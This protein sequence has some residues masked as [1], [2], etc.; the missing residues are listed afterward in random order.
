MNDLE[1]AGR[2]WTNGRHPT[3][4]AAFTS[5][6]ICACVCV[7]E[8]ALTLFD[9]VR[10]SVDEDVER[11]HHAGDGDD[12]EGDRTHDLPPLARRH[13]QLLPLRGHKG[14]GRLV[15]SENF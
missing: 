7:R 12:V 8:S 9:F 15:R 6:C 5:K 13:L 1:T 14:R 4:T 3:Q 10:C 11:P 2:V